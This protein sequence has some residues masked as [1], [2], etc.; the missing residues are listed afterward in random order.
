MEDFILK[1]CPKC[2][3]WMFDFDPR[4]EIEKCLNCGYEKIIENVREYYIANDM[5][6]KLFLSISE[7]N[8]KSDQAFI[9]HSSSDI[10]IGEEAKSLEELATKVKEIPFKS[11]Q[12]HFLRGD[13]ERWIT[14]VIGN[15]KLAKQISK[16]REQNNIDSTLRDRLYKTILVGS[17]T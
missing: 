9:F 10:C 14:D 17:V 7:V 15:S 5:T 11:L 4:R 2:G 13:F 6:Y 12:Y 16:L 8:V 3:V 1:E